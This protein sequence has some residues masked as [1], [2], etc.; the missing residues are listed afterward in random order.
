MLA[1]SALRLVFAVKTLF[2][3]TADLVAQYLVNLGSHV[4]PLTLPPPH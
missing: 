4:A 3:H 1:L 2:N